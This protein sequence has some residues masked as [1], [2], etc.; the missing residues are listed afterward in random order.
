MYVFLSVI[1]KLKRNL[2]WNMD[3]KP[4]LEPRMVSLV[5]DVDIAG[6]GIWYIEFQYLMLHHLTIP[7][8]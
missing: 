8:I 2:N 6:Y 1:L 4:G 7:G 5:V 3:W